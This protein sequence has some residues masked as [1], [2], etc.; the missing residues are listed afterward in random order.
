ME[1]TDLQIFEWINNHYSSALDQVMWLVSGRLTAVPLYL[2]LLWQ[3]IKNYR[4]KTIFILLG[5]IL[6][7]T[8]SDQTSVLVKQTVKRYRPC[9]NEVL[10]DQVHL[11]NGHCGGKYGF[12]SSHASN[13]MALTVLVIL[14]LPFAA[15]S[16]FLIIWPLL[17]GYSRVYLAAHYP[18]DVLVGWLAG[19]MLAGLIALGLRRLQVFPLQTVQS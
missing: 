4:R 18:S 7:I 15:W 8:A 14:L 3:I 10:K 11:V 6:L 17:V 16:K 1:Q 19:A 12:Y 2:I 5:I 9:H 13:T